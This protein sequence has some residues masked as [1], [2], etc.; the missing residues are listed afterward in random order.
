MKSLLKFGVG[1]LLIA[2]MGSLIYAAP[3]DDDNG[4]SADV[5]IT[6]PG[7]KQMQLSPAEMTM[8][9]DEAIENVRGMLRHVTQLREKAQREKDIIKL[10]CVNDK[11]VLLKGTANIAEEDHHAVEIAISNSDEKGRY[12][13]YGDLIVN[14]D[15]AKD[16]RDAADACVGDALTYIGK[17]DVQVTGPSN[18]IVPGDHVFDPG[19][20]PPTY[21]TPWD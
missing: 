6:T 14:H 11:L 21:R 3:G 5:S 16:L 9:S 2:G 7:A 13:A 20:E 15:K 1:G 10:N 17:T 19:I 4:V 12:T 8:A 18:P